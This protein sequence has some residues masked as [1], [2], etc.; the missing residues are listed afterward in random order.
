[1]SMIEYFEETR[2][3][4]KQ[5]RERLARERQERVSRY[6]DSAKVFSAAI[7]DRLVDWYGAT[8]VRAQDVAR[9]YGQ[10]HAPADRVAAF[11]QEAPAV[12]AK[13]AQELRTA[14]AKLEEADWLEAA[15]WLRAPVEA[16]PA[17]LQPAALTVAEPVVGLIGRAGLFTMAPA[18]L[19]VFD[20][21]TWPYPRNPALLR[22]WL[23]AH[24]AASGLQDVDFIPEPIEREKRFLW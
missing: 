14:I 3:T 8:L 15:R 9:G 24:H 17:V 16:T 10:L 11:Q 2:T 5:E 7:A 1:M 22:A 19:N 21:G 20:L 23:D 6:I 4:T 13:A 12:A 18:K